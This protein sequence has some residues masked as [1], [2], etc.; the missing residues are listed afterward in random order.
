MLDWIENSAGWIAGV[1]AGGGVVIVLARWVVKRGRA[2]ARKWDRAREALVGREEIR[3]PDTGAVLVPATPGLGQRLVGIEGTLIA[4]SDTRT[5]MNTLAGK[6]GELASQLEHHV[7]ESRELELARTREREEMWH[8]IQAVATPMPWD[9]IE[10][11]GQTEG[12]EPA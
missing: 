8:A 12:S 10:R 9:G 11:R 2:F 3:H 4:L 7:T 6:V 5:E 1:A